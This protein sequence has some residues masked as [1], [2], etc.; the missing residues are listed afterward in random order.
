VVTKLAVRSQN[1]RG[2]DLTRATLNALLK[3]PWHRATGGKEQRKWGAYASEDN[4]LRFARELVPA[5]DKQKSAEAELMDWADD[6]T[7][8][9]HDIADFYRAG[10]IPMERLVSVKDETERRAFFHEVF[11]R[12]GTEDLEGFSRSQME[13]SFQELIEWLPFAS[14]F[15][16]TREQ[17]A[18]LR[19]ACSKLIDRYVGAIRL[20][21][22]TRDNGRRVEINPAMRQEVFMLKQ[23]TWSYVILN[24]MLTTQQHGLRTLIR[25]LFEILYKS[26]KKKNYLVF[27]FSVRERFDPEDD[28]PDPSPRIIADYIA[29]MT[30]QQARSMYLRL[31]G[32]SPGSA[33][34]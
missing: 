33:L 24:P 5:G 30:E 27:P 11:D 19:G 6:V 31:T 21:E 25:Q 28:E 2:L 4:E 18:V 3:Y 12:L 15:V 34:H 22:P 23:L 32:V 8:A 1:H 13:Q 14:R 29:G 17:R 10:L 26:A 7:Y 20:R 9:V 16:G